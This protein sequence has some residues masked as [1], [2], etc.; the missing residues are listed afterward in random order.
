MKTVG[1]CFVEAQVDNK[2]PVGQVESKNL[3]RSLVEDLHNK[4]AVV[5]ANRNWLFVV[6]AENTFVDPYNSVAA[7]ADSH[8]KSED[9]CIF[10]RIR[11]CTFQSLP[12]LTRCRANRDR[13]C[14]RNIRSRLCATSC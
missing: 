3:P 11:F 4:A 6:T 7:A 9:F 8:C 10:S 12:P 1:Y 2:A 14:S 5:G 13:S